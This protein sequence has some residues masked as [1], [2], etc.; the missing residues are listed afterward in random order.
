[1][2][3]L[4]MT[5]AL[6]LAG[7]LV[8]T[9][10][11]S[12]TQQTAMQVDAG[13]SLYQ[14][15]CAG[16]HMPDLVGRNEAP[17]LAGANFIATWGNRSTRALLETIRTTMPPGRA[18]SLSPEESVNIAAFILA[19]NGSPNAN[20]PFSAITDSR[21]GSI[22]SGR[23][24]ASSQPAQPPDK[25]PVSPR[26]V[27]VAGEVKN[28]TPVTDAMLR[29][30]SPADWLMIRGNY[31]AWNTSALSEITPANVKNL[32]LAWTWTMNDSGTSQAAPLAHNGTIYINSPGNIVQALN[33][34]TGELIW[35]NHVGP[36]ATGF[37]TAG[38][39]RG[40]AL[41]EDKLFLATTDAR[42]VALNAKTGAQVWEATIADRSKGYTNTSGPIVIHGK[43]IQGLAGCD[44][45]KETGCYISAYDAT[46]GKQLW[47][48]N[49]VAREDEPGGDTWGNLSN[50]FRAGGE[51]WITGS[52]DPSL[53]LT[54]WGV[55]Q[56]KPWVPASRGT[57]VHDKGLYTGSTIAL[58]PDNGT[59]AWYYQHTPGEALDL[60][61]VFE[62]VL[63]DHN[64]RKLVF[65][66]GKPGIL[67]KLDRRNGRFLG[68]KE[69]VFQNIF[70]SIDPET[71]A[72]TY[73]ADI[74]AAKTGE[75]IQACPSTEG[76]HNWHA[77]TYHPGTAQLIIP[78]SQSCLEMS[79]RKVEFKE[80]SGGTAGDRRFYE[81]PG[82]DGNIGKLAAYD[83]NTMKEMW[84][85]QQRAPFLTSAMSTAGGLA[86][87][88]DLDQTF[89]AVDVKTGAVVWQTK[90]ATSVQGFPMSF[91]IDGKQY[92]AVTTGMG[93]GSPRQVP[94]IIAPELRP[95]SSGTAL[96]VFTLP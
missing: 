67:W 25:K 68:Y 43:V 61:E 30:P 79:G 52:Y 10:S 74:A 29:N 23:P 56:A 78:L 20:Q 22:A 58:N 94:S 35:E 6:T 32:R 11:F 16:C 50:M 41:F 1:M 24:A 14:A 91:S 2:R 33:G 80:G 51:S 65:T 45:Y 96:Y 59:L 84:S 27:T 21:I 49:T 34:R 28:F 95:P 26:G 66:I 9:S 88:G 31:Q 60:D 37:G 83:V 46:T 38:A 40:M 42:L 17:P 13:R 36:D 69:T 19:S 54:F 48:F 87:V 73:R 71:G 57:T 90:L 89:K 70:D 82:S 86:F 76:G 12:A 53:N 3:S 72:P 62:R 39:M 85:I 44:R 81:M 5:L 77:M 55:A 92:V 7:T 8:L 93:G 63:V 47:K 64:G 4:A 75:W 18:G 15:N